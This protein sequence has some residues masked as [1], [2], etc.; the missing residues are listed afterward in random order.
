MDIAQE[1]SPLPDPHR[2]GSDAVLLTSSLKRARSTAAGLFGPVGEKSIICE[3]FAEQSFGDWEGQPYDIA[4]G[5]LPD[6]LD[7]MAAFRPPGGE[8]FEDVVTRTR[9]AMERLEAL[10]GGQSL[11]VVSHA[12]VIRAALAVA[13]D[14]PAGR[15]LGFAVD[16]LSAT[17][18]TSFA[19]AGWRVDYV[20]R[21]A[22]P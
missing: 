8:S 17:S 9:A 7:A 10:Y 21:P 16:P 3:D 4:Q 22:C 1:C 15:A 18:M 12:G 2:F 13:L 6:D 5:R 14:I 20:N 11:V 19:G